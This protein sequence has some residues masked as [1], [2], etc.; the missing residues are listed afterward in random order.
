MQCQHLPNPSHAFS[1]SF[2]NSLCTFKLIPFS[3]NSFDPNISLSLASISAHHIS[4]TFINFP[5]FYHLPSLTANFYMTISYFLSIWP[6]LNMCA[7]MALDLR[8]S[9]QF[10]QILS[11]SCIADFQEKLLVLSKVYPVG[12]LSLYHVSLSFG[13]V[14]RR[15]KLT[16]HIPEFLQRRSSLIAPLHPRLDLICTLYS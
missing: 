10:I 11:L 8:N 1:H 6:N 13:Q 3:F 15:I 2:S 9:K 16:C 14:F 12:R 7:A 4:T 5:Y